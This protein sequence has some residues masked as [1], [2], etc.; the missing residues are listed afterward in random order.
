MP[1]LTD[2]LTL[3]RGERRIW[4]G[5]VK[6][7]A[8]AVVDIT[9]A[10]LYFTVRSTFPAGT[11]TDDTDSDVLFKKTVGSGI[12]FSGLPDGKF[13]I[14]VDKADTNTVEIGDAGKGYKY[15]VEIVESGQSDPKVLAQ[16]I[17]T[18]LT[19]IVRGV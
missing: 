6:D 16:G 14:R 18:L 13:E 3:Y 5:A 17:L 1:V 8:G 9:D 10:S 7:D 11:I 15:A 12:T 19:D 2:E 4:A